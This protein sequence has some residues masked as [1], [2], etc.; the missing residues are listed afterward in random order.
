[1]DNDLLPCE[2]K[3]LQRILDS[4]KSSAVWLRVMTILHPNDAPYAVPSRL[5]REAHS[6]PANIRFEEIDDVLVAQ[7][8]FGFQEEQ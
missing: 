5:V 2:L 8:A 3:R 1:M 7:D 6:P 4:T